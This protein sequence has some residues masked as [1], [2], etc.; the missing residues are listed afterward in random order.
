MTAL[1]E[2]VLVDE[3]WIRRLAPSPRSWIQLVRK[4]THG[5]GDGDAFDAEEGKLVLS[6]EARTGNCGIRQ[7]R[8]RRVVQDI[9]SCEARLP[10]KSTRDHGVVAQYPDGTSAYAMPVRFPSATSNVLRFDPSRLAL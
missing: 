3:L 7:P 1:L 8:E 5:N 6:A 10:V 9:V 2:S 4:D